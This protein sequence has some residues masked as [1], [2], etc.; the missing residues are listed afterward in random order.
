MASLFHSPLTASKCQGS[1]LDI[2]SRD[3]DEAHHQHR[4]GALDKLSLELILE[5]LILIPYN[6]ARQLLRDGSCS[7]NS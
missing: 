6:V 2:C 7:L 1:L 4:A 5:L 3:Y